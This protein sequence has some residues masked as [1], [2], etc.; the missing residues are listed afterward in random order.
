MHQDVD[1]IPWANRIALAFAL[2]AVMAKIARSTFGRK[3]WRVLVPVMLVMIFVWSRF[4]YREL[5]WKNEK[6]PPEERWDYTDYVY[7]SHEYPFYRKMHRFGGKDDTY[8]SIS[9]SGPM[10]ET[11]KLHGQWKTSIWRKIENPN[12]LD[13]V[14]DH[15]EQWYW[16]GEPITEGDWHLRNR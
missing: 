12:S 9:T 11:G 16:Y 3:S 8:I 6:D 1:G 10:S 15:S 7:R 2:W 14:F 5:H 13:E 4:D